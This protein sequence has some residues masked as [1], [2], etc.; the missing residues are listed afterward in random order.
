MCSLGGQRYIP[1]GTGWSVEE[2]VRIEVSIA[3]DGGHPSGAARCLL[4]TSLASKGGT[5]IC[6]VGLA[7]WE[8]FLQKAPELN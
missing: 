6:H 4:S 8:S 3:E 7:L 1:T 5:P 2:G